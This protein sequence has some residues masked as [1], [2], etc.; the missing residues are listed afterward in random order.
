MPKMGP[1]F[2]LYWIEKD[3]SSGPSGEPTRMMEVDHAYRGDNL[4][5]YSE[6]ALSNWFPA[7]LVNIGETE[8]L[9]PEAALEAF[10]SSLIVEIQNMPRRLAESQAMVD[11]SL[12]E[13]RQAETLVKLV[14]SVLGLTE[15]PAPLEESRLRFRPLA[16]RPVTLYSCE[17]LGGQPHIVEHLF[18]EDG[19]RLWYLDRRGA[20]GFHYKSTL[21]GGL[22]W[23]RFSPASAVDALA[24]SAR[25]CHQTRLESHRQLEASLKAMEADLVLCDCGVGSF[26]RVVER[27]RQSRK[28]TAR[29]KRL[30]E[31][32]RKPKQS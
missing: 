28:R 27:A 21:K 12:Q 2:P 4:V 25:E 11:R 14:R 5:C 3:W 10:R 8:F 19:D 29:P 32:M 18:E 15:E 24:D 6:Y 23:L 30:P 1:A 22:R 31:R 7:D 20:R 17:I 13:L 26:P 16:P 9:T